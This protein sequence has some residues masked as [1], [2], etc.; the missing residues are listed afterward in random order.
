MCVWTYRVLHLRGRSLT[1][2]GSKLNWLGL[3]IGL[4]VRSPPE[5][6]YN[7]GWG[8]VRV[9]LIHPLETSR[10][11]SLALAKPPSWN[12]AVLYVVLPPCTCGYLVGATFE[13]LGWNMRGREGHWRLHGTARRVRLRRD[14]F[15]C[16][17]RLVVISWPIITLDVDFMGSKILFCASVASLYSYS[18]IRVIVFKY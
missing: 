1:R 8:S 12:L 9:N 17:A 4:E 13:A 14:S 3:P 7:E 11:A 18:G 16:L 2:I 15:H 10:R 5:R 6:L